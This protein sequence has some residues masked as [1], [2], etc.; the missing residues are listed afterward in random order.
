MPWSDI[1]GIETSFSEQGVNINGEAF[2]LAA[3]SIARQAHVL[4]ILLLSSVAV[5]E[6]EQ[7]NI[8]RYFIDLLAVF[9]FP[10][11]VS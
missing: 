10:Y 11:L 3:R 6:C 1:F 9:R 7:A 5:L 8:L 4:T 2:A